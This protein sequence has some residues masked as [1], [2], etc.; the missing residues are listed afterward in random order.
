M[1]FLLKCQIIFWCH[2]AFS[3]SAVLSLPSFPCLCLL[4]FLSFKNLSFPLNFSPTLCLS[5]LP[6]SAVSTVKTQHRETKE[7]KDHFK[8]RVIEKPGFGSRPDRAAPMKFG[9]VLKQLSVTLPSSKSSRRVV[10][11]LFKA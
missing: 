3:P 10:T 8:T 9:L 4:S 11:I 1:F 5:S 2:L 7:K 6:P